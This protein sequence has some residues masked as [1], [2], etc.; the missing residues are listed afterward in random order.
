MNPAVSATIQPISGDFLTAE[1]AARLFERSQETSRKEVGSLSLHWLS[2][3]EGSS[4]LIQGPAGEFIQIRGEVE[5][6]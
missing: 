6:H 2:N 5:L 3:D 1:Q 4:C